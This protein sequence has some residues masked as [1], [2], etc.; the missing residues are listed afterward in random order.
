MPRL[1]FYFRKGSRGSKPMI[2]QDPNRSLAKREGQALP[3][4][5]ALGLPYFAFQLK[6]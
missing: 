3:F 4:W 5:E 6:C 2:A 1:T